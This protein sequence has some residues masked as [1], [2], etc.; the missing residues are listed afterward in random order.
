MDADVFP[1]SRHVL[2]TLELLVHI[3]NEEEVLSMF[4]TALD[5][6]IGFGRC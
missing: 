1:R 2:S 6:D 5:A 3:Q 4:S